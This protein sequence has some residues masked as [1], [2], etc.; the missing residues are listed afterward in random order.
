VTYTVTAADASTKAYTVTV[1]V[2]LMSA[3]NITAFSFTSPAST[4]VINGTDIAV[5]VPYGTDVK[6]LTPLIVIS[7][8]ATISPVSR[9][10]QNFTGPVIYNV[11][12]E[13]SSTQ[14]YQVN[15]G[16][17]AKPEVSKKSNL[18]II[19]AIIVILIGIIVVAIGGFFL[20]QTK[21]RSKTQI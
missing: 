1:T 7:P 11:T 3:R 13:D 20:Y 9:A 15:V 2:G 6:N 18:G 10:S 5:T 8:E 4:G 16:I 19:I 17:A 21:L 14:I 12:A